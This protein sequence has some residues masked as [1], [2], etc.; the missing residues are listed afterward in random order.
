[1]ALIMENFA[2]NYLSCQ[3]NLKKVGVLE[4]LLSEIGSAPV[5]YQAGSPVAMRLS[6]S[7]KAFSMASEWYISYMS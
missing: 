4:G 6:R 3:L 5:R 7:W 1:M 2:G